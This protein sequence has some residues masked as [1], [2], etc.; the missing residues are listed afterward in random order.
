M[1]QKICIIILGLFLIPAI[2]Y[3]QKDYSSK[4]K[5]EIAKNYKD[6]AQ[7]KSSAYIEIDSIYYYLTE[8]RKIFFDIGHDSMIFECNQNLLYWYI[9]QLEFDKALSLIQ[10]NQEV[11]KL[12]EK[13]MMRSYFDRANLFGRNNVND[14]DSTLFYSRKAYS[15]AL[16]Q[17]DTIHMLIGAE[18]MAQSYLMFPDS[19]FLIPYLYDK[20]KVLESH[21]RETKSMF[22]IFH[23]DMGVYYL[24][25]GEPLKAI[26]HLEE[27]SHLEQNNNDIGFTKWA[28]DYLAEAYS[29]T[30]QYEKAYK[31]IEKSVLFASQIA[32]KNK[33]EAIQKVKYQFDTEQKEK[34]IYQLEETNELKEKTAARQRMFLWILGI[35][36]LIIIGLLFSLYRNAK[37]R[38]RADQKLITL[39]Q[40][41][42]QQQTKLFTNITHE[43]R[44]PLTVILGMADKLTDNQKISNMIKRN[45]EQ[46]LQLVNQ[47]LSLSKADAGVLST[48]P[49]QADIISYLEYI[50]ESH[51][52]LAEQKD[53][54]LIMH[55]EVEIVSMDFDPNKMNHVISNL[56]TNAIKYTEAKGKVV[57][58]CDKVDN[59]L[60]IRVKDNGIGIAEENQDRIFDRFYQTDHHT[61][62]GTGIGLAFVKEM[63]TIMDGNISL[64][65]SLNKGSEFTILLPITNLAQTNSK[66][67]ISQS[68]EEII[69]HESYEDL[70]EKSNEKIAL[71]VE[72]NKDVSYYI[73]SC[74]AENFKVET[75]ENGAKGFTKAQEI[76]PDIII[77]DVMMPVMDGYELCNKLKQHI[78][79]D[80]IPIILLTAK[81]SQE[82]KLEGL[83]HGADAYLTKPFDELE[84][85]LR[86]EKLLEL[87]DKLK[88]KYQ[89]ANLKENQDTQNPFVIQLDKILEKNY[90]DEQFSVNA[91]AEKV[92]F[93][94]MQ[95]HR[96]IRSITNKTT[97]EY[98]RD[99]RLSK[100]KMLI[101]STDSTIAEI[102]FTAGFNNPSYFTKLFHTK[103]G[104]TPSSLKTQKY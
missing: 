18:Y 64:Q 53:I 20:S 47:L 56:L 96:K 10:E 70:N 76:I 45:G 22:K 99:F 79:T 100:A 62:G 6:I 98:I 19:L 92:H 78:K 21:D 46:M 91:L 16:E 73:K 95:L 101:E 74:L 52:G 83:K 72:D 93:S 36:S 23:V 4:Q 28:L 39:Q 89:E 84:L 61:Y 66:L 2:L 24:A 3:S 85:L 43:F 17:K 41:I 31:A 87:R 94:R 68:K 32:D 13:W 38:R 34:I 40:N 51:L 80:H 102:C 57:L 81:A 9:Q 33:L 103:Y 37:E 30:G 50:V 104:I 69:A 27:Q 29:R 77:S 1:L 54:R 59:Q 65:S 44:T 86:V 63:I 55:S 42:T 7:Q 12:N 25:I 82:E 15:M 67:H 48:N 58:L 90:S 14:R 35:G 11:A 5:Y 49:I 97:S 26:L 60:R 88:I 8:A 75:V 71:V